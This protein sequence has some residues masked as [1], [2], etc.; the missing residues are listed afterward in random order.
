MEYGAMTVKETKGQQKRNWLWAA[1]ILA[2]LV[3]LLLFLWRTDFFSSVRSLED[4][5]AYIRQFSPFSYGIFFLVQL[6]SVILAPIPSNATS[7]AGAALF[8]TLPAFLLTYGA[9]FLGSLAVFRLVRSLGRPFVERF[10]Q[11]ESME[12]Y[13]ALIERKQDAF[14]AVAFLLPGFP[15]D[16]LCFLAGLTDMPFRRFALM[17]LLFRPWGLLVSCAVG[18][19]AL[20]LPLWAL[21]ALCAA[22]VGVFLAAMK[23]G[24]R[25]EEALLRRLKN[26][27]KK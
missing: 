10:V 26:R 2:L 17:V 7:L 4:M 5:R 21:L 24:D 19:S 15:D 13:M 25:W 14:F 8:G 6:A 11:R 23:F 27:K 18:G 22:G 20:Q 9:V 12:K 16:I 3:F 1:A